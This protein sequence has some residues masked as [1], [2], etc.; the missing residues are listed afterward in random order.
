MFKTLILVRHYIN[1]AKQQ[2]LIS[3]TNVSLQTPIMRITGRFMAE[4]RY[5]Y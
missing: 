1:V 2:C 4:R 3:P 5:L